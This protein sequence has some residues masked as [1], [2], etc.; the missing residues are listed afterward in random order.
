MKLFKISLF[1]LSGLLLCFSAF[2]QITG[3]SDDTDSTEVVH[4][5]ITRNAQKKINV[6]DYTK[7]VLSSDYDSFGVVQKISAVKD[8]HFQFKTGLSLLTTD[9]FYSSYGLSLGANY[10]FTESFAL[11]LGA[12][13][14]LSNQNAQARNLH[15]F[16]AVP[17]E[18]I[19]TIKSTTNVSLFWSPIYGK[20]SLLNDKILPFE[21]YLSIGTAQVTSQLN[22]SVNAATASLGHFIS[23][24]NYSALDFNLQW[25]SYDSKNLNNQD[26]N[27]NSVLL[28]VGYDLLWQKSE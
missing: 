12:S 7:N 10:N 2:A 5:A 17:T 18:G 23:L 20:W 24:S 8:S 14:F 26:R 25:L 16:Y 15:D 13:T 9:T 4:K 3:A 19:P 1:I 28:T 21:F 6:T 22:T 27:V 11:G